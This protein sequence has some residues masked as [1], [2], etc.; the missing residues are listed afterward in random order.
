[1]TIQQLLATDTTGMSDAELTEVLHPFFPDT[2]PTKV[3]VAEASGI[4]ATL[5]PE[6]QEM[7]RAAKGPKMVFGK[8]TP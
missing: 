3:L 6:M 5:P 2:R 1:M 7:L 8:P 4:L